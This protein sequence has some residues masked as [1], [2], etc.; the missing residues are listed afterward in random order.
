MDPA[1]ERLEL[2]GGLARRILARQGHPGQDH[3]TTLEPTRA[4]TAPTRCCC[5]CA[6]AARPPANQDETWPLE[7]GCVGQET[8]GAGGLA[9]ALRTVPVVLDI[10]ERVRR[11]A[12]GRVDHRL[13]QPGRHRHPGAAAGRATGR[14]G[15]A[16]WRSASSAGSPRCSASRPSAVELD[17]VGPQPPD[18][19]ARRPGST[20]WTCCR[21]CWPTH[22]DAI[23]DRPRAAAPSCCA[24]SASCRRTTCATSTR[25]TR[26]SASSCG[27]RR[28]PPRSPRSSASCWSCTPT[29]RS[30]RSRSCWRSAAART[31]PRPPS[32]LAAALLGDG[33]RRQ[34]VVN[35]RN[36]GTLPFLP[37]DAVIEVPAPVDRP[38]RDAAAGRAARA[39][40]R[41]AGRPR[42]GVRGAGAGRGAARRRRP[43]L[44]GAARP[45]AGRPVRAAPSGSP[46]GCSRTT[47]STCRGP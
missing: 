13:H 44:R 8:T 35:V 31:T 22:G 36:D 12:P 38:G 40:V 2:V 3:V 32:Q 20:A 16:T 17:H 47:G 5:S 6:S 21:S 23:A 7:C 26:S 34:Q 14:S 1:A 4:S 41:R 39:A 28:G 10:A 11:A 19:G 30:T 45:P 42:H 18:L 33:A 29:R 27:S 15:C 37:D 46:T 25:T 24:R 9:K 43:G